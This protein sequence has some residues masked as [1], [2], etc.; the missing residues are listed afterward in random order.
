MNLQ[1]AE[2]SSTSFYS[3]QIYE[4]DF[5]TGEL[6]KVSPSFSFPK[7][8]IQFLAESSKRLVVVGAR[9]SWEFVLFSFSFLLFIQKRLVSFVYFI[10]SIKDLIV[11]IVMWRRGLL[12]KPAVHS[13]V[14]AISSVALVVGGIFVNSVEPTDFTR[15]LVLASEN[16][17]QTVIPEDRP[18]SEIVK[19]E[20]AEGES[21]SQ[22]AEKF[23]VSVDSIKWANDMT[24]VDSVKPG[25]VLSIPPVS[26]VI[27]KVRKGDTLASIAK[28]F[29]ADAQTIA[30]YPFNY[31]TDSLEVTVGQT[32][33]IPGGKKPD[34]TP[35]PYT[36]PSYSQPIFYAAGGTGLFS[37]PVR[38]S[39]NQYP[40]WWHPAIDIGAPYGTL[41]TAAGSGKVVAATWGNYGYGNYVSIDHGNGYSTTY[42]HLSS[43]KVSLGQTVG[44][45]QA[46]GN[47]GCTGFCT[48][49]HLH[50]AVFR[51][52]SV[53][54][55]LSLLP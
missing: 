5:L 31:I 2:S 28:T 26:G 3:S 53:V 52:G 48:G 50:F 41:V 7:K 8:T 34:P 11:K 9:V 13:G 17:T 54:N 19:Y 36:R 1:D 49:P 25:D 47:V 18:R 45:G 39:L 42:A 27:Y 37:W 10:E 14:L 33:I 20:V 23:N 35:L 46:I 43:I 51:G 32:L 44:K 38:G 29:S 12:F 16:T 40:S 21:L 24:D 6:V 15:D 55:P 30:T 22:I 4:Y